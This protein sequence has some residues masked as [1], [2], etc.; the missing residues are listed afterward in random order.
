MQ[1]ARRFFS[2]LSF[3]LKPI[4]MFSRTVMFGKSI[5]SLRH[6]INAVRQRRGG[7]AQFDRLPSMRISPSSHE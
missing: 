7:L 6:Q 3:S 2:S 4:R 5:G 1:S